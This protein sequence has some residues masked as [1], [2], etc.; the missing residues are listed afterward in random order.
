MPK[1][2]PL[3]IAVL[4]L[5][6]GPGAAPVQNST[7]PSNVSIAISPPQTSLLTGGTLQFHAQVENATDQT[8]AWS[9]LEGA[10]G[11]NINSDGLY[12]APSSAGAFHVIATAQ[13]QTAMSTI[14]V[15]SVPQ[16]PAVVTV[17]LT[18][19]TAS[20]KPGDSVTFTASVGGNSDNAVL[21]STDS[22]S[23]DA[24]GVFVAPAQAGVAHVT[25]ASHVDR[26]AF[27]VATVAAKAAQQ[28]TA[29]V[30][31]TTDTR[32]SWTASGGSID[33]TGLW[34]APSTAGAFHITAQS[35]AD[36]SKSATASITVPQPPPPSNIVVAITPASIKLQIGDGT[37][38]PFNA[39]VSGTSD[40]A[41]TWSVQESPTGGTIDQTGLYSIPFQEGT[42]HVV[43]RSRADPTKFAVAPVTVGPNSN[44]L[45]DHGGP[46]ETAS[47]TFLIWWGDVTQYPADAR[48]SM[49]GF[50]SGL[51]RSSFL[52]IADEYMRGATAT[53]SFAGSIFNPDTPPASPG[54][55]MGNMVCQVIQSNGISLRDGDIFIVTTSFFPDDAEGQYCAFHSFGA[56]S[57]HP[58]TFIYAP[59]PA[60]SWCELRTVTC[61]NGISSNV[62]SMVSSM[63]HEVM[64]TIT[65]PF[66]S[67][68]LNVGG[69]E[70]G[71]LCGTD[72][73]APFPNATYQVSGLYSNAKHG[74]VTH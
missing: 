34:L 53:S 3:C 52:A 39:T 12:T 50:L 65:D 27:A 59:N 29:H 74:C 73:C 35:L 23:V 40:Q 64:E 61:D 5:A 56:C 55:E 21:W 25:A 19:T 22:G 28:F 16:L 26:T 30:S 7:A 43:A 41:V 1:T 20:V 2:G 48:A 67:A 66:E 10:S 14:T 6:C 36:P 69:G 9:V 24:T 63:S 4:S 32:V 57:G 33:Q 11:G 72:W 8:V 71:D 44:D 68:W 60:N 58:M 42:F 49:E 51:N 38:W 47:R 70:M 37:T 54:G 17:T 62:N 15:T 46:V 45:I 18:P 13:G 31:G